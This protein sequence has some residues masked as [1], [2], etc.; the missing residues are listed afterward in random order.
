MVDSL[1]G[2]D[3]NLAVGVR[4]QDCIFSSRIFP[5]LVIGSLPRFLFSPALFRATPA[6]NTLCT[7]GEMYVLGEVLARYT[8]KSKAIQ[9]AAL[10]AIVALSFLKSK[11]MNW[12]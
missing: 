8:G 5:V 12:W 4:A 11:G 1:G 2:H 7:G 9:F 10:V 3:R 6:G